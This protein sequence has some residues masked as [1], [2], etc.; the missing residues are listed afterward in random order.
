MGE[1]IQID[2]S[3][4]KDMQMATNY[5]TK[6]SASLNTWKMHTKTKMRLSHQ[7]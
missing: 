6:I 5:M 7:L 2:I 3:H 1:I 4:K